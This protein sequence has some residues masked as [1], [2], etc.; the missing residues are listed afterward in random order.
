MS[1]ASS[2]HLGPFAKGWTRYRGKALMAEID[3]RSRT[4]D[5]ELLGLS[6]TKG[7]LRKSD[8]S[9]RSAQA[10]SHVGY[11]LVR[12]GDLVCNKMQA[13]NGVFGISN[14]NGMT[15][16]DYAI[17]DFAG[18]C[19]SRLI[20]YMVKTPLFAADFKSRSNG[21]GTGF[22]RL[23]P[24]EFLSTDFWLPERKE[25]D[26]IVAYLDHETMRIH[27]L[28]EKKGRFI[29]LLKE[30]RA[31]LITH[32]VMGDK[33]AQTSSITDTQ[34]PPGWKHARLKFNLRRL[35]EKQTK[36]EKVIALENIESWTGRLIETTSTFDGEGVAFK[37]GDILFGKLRPY[38]AKVY[39]AKN[40]GEAVGDVWVL[41]PQSHIEPRFAA[42]QLLETCFIDHVNGSTNGAKMPRAEWG[43]VGSI[44][45]PTPPYEVQVE[46]ADYLD[47]ET[48]RIDGLIATT[49]R[50]IELLQERRTAL[51]TAAV[52][53][54]IDVRNAA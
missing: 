53:G 49:Y 52:T 9:Q 12:R 54:Q 47:L 21:I 22:M 8:I 36:N 44:K 13:W 11:K 37:R 7:V 15:S 46:I 20:E 19:S 41:R 39:L 33:A 23:N 25:Q 30:K 10:D 6:G 17:Y 28:I 1:F 4:G 40:D 51:I 5:E 26:E 43:F 42:Y 48:A 31:A 34:L 29:E 18:D 24:S 45:V 35:S 3:N 14:Y 38:L 50:S 2:L 32:A 16:P 27:G